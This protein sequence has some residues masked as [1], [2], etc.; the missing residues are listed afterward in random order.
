MEKEEIRENKEL[1]RIVAL[2]LG[3]MPYEEI[4]DENF[5]QVEEISLN[6][7]LING[8]ESGI[9]VSAISLF[10][11]LKRLKLSNYRITKEAIDVIA[12]LAG[13]RDLE[14]FGAEFEKGI[15][16]EGLEHTL[17]SLRLYNCLEI[18]FPYPRLSEVWLSQTDIDF[19]KIDL[20]TARKISIRD[21]HIRN[22]CDL[23]DFPNIESVNLDGSVLIKDDEKVEDIKVSS[24]TMY[25][26]KAEVE[27]INGERL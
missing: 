25:T 5:N 24:K 14:I 13:L 3:K 21:G 17:K 1:K 10:P 4:S 15:T 23:T 22:I 6:T 8:Q 2:K 7:H 26:H 16:F 9:G 20:Q 12:S 19:S 11:N 18:D 27:L